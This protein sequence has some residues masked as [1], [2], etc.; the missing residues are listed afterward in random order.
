MALLG[1]MGFTEEQVA[2]I[3]THHADK[4]EA[5]RKVLNYFEDLKTSEGEQKVPDGI[6]HP[7]VFLIRNIIRELPVFLL[8]NFKPHIP[9]DGEESD[10]IQWSIMPVEE[11][12]QIMAAS[13]V[14]QEDLKLT[15]NRK[16]RALEFQELYR[17]LISAIDPKNEEETLKGIAK[18]SSVIKIPRP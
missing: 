16:L 14:N 1:K 9:Q 4:L 13:Y 5:F 2:K 15:D 10:G 12:C 18:R 17:E 8:K 3:K 7:P 6:D 11:F